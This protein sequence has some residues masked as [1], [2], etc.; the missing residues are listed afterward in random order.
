MPL[1]TAVHNC[2]GGSGRQQRRRGAGMRTVTR[3]PYRDPV[4]SEDTDLELRIGESSWDPD[5]QS[6]VGQARR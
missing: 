4:T 5:S 6:V 2:L 1:I 3:V